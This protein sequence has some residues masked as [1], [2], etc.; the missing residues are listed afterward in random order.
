ML[1]TWPWRSSESEARPGLMF[2][3]GSLL[4]CFPALRVRRGSWSWGSRLGG[5][6]ICQ[7]DVWEG[8]SGQ[9]TRDRAHRVLSRFPSGPLPPAQSACWHIAGARRPPRHARCRWGAATSATPVSDQAWANGR[10]E[11]PGSSPPP[12]SQGTGGEVGSSPRCIMLLEATPRRG[13]PHPTKERTWPS[14]KQGEKIA[15]FCQMCVCVWCARVCWSTTAGHA[16]HETAAPR[17]PDADNG[18][19]GRSLGG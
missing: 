7:V 15:S 9:A 16:G 4:A 17:E 10:A 12:V 18:V 8:E 6:M 1:L 11:L 2:A 13:S 19:R 5:A 3:D 14:A